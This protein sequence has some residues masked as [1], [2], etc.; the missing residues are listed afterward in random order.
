MTCRVKPATQCHDKGHFEETATPQDFCADVVD[1]TASTGDDPRAAGPF[2][3][4]VRVV[5][6]SKPSVVDP[7]QTRVLNTVVWYP[8]APGA[9]PVDSGYG[10]VLNAPLEASG[11]P[12]PVV[13]FSHGSC[14]VPTQSKFLW[15]LVASRG[16]VVVAPP[17][18]GNTLAEFPQC[19]AA[20]ALVAA[21]LERPQDIL[22]A[23]DQMLAA[24]ADPLSPFFGALDATRIG[25]A[26]HSFGGWTTYKVMPLDARFKVAVPMAPA[27]P[28]GVVPL[29][30]PSLTMLSTLDT[31]VDEAAIRTQFAAAASPKFE[32]ELRNTGHFAYSD[33]CFPSPDC[34]PPATLTQDEAH[35]AVL[36]WVPPFLERYLAGDPGFAPFFVLP[37]PPGA[38]L[39]A[40]P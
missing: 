10:A 36:R 6:L 22:F 9:G 11:G 23:L 40:L 20:Q 16:F 30:V 18:P 7:M 39:T 37:A 17:H 26:G 31:Y 19:G 38:V 2:G 14:G 3:A 34:N 13:M 21:A 5:T 29:T 4:G 33:N 12:Y 24:S 27:V 15:P 1:W 8:T 28:A 32:I 35:A 25:M